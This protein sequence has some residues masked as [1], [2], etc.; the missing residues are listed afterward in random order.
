MNVTAET[1]ATFRGYSNDIPFI[2][3]AYFASMCKNAYKV[4]H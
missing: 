1:C 2:A 3:L 4:T